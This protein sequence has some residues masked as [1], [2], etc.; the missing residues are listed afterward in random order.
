MGRTSP[1]RTGFRSR[2]PKAKYHWISTYIDENFL[3]TSDGTFE[4]EDLWNRVPIFDGSQFQSNEGMSERA[5]LVRVVSDVHAQLWMSAVGDASDNYTAKVRVP[6]LACLTIG[7]FHEGQYAQPLSEH[8]DVLPSPNYP[9]YFLANDVVR[10][11]TAFVDFS[12]SGSNSA[13]GVEIASQ[14]TS[15]RQDVPLGLSCKTRKRL[16]NDSCLWLDTWPHVSLPYAIDLSG[17]DTASFVLR[18]RLQGYMRCLIRS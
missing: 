14:L 4:L 17:A 5:T 6:I 8:F 1:R 16:T 9:E 13:G 11:R 10:A 2:K 12:L 3:L 15:G 7:E 18:L